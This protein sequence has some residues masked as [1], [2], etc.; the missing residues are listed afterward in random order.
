MTPLATSGRRFCEVRKTA[1][2]ATPDVFGSNGSGAAFC[3]AQPI[4]GPLVNA[5]QEVG[6]SYDG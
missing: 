6:L 5:F 2:N 3:F 1:E 4:G